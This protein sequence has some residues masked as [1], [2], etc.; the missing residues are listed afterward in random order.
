MLGKQFGECIE[1]VQMSQIYQRLTGH[2]AYHFAF[3]GSFLC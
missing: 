2:M 3:L 1:S